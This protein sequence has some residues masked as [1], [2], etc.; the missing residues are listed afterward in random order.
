MGKIKH[1]QKGQGYHARADHQKPEKP[2]SKAKVIMSIIIAATG[3]AVAFFGMGFNT[4]ALI[5]GGIIGAVV[6]WLIG[7]SMDNLAKRQN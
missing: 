6:G 2:V 4:T 5:I 1:S 7:T 3:V